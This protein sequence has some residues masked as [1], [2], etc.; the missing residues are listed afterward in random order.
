MGTAVRDGSRSGP[1]EAWGSEAGSRSSR[2]S[3]RIAQEPGATVGIEVEGDGA[4]GVPEQNAPEHGGG[5][6]EGRA[7]IAGCPIASAIDSPL[8]NASIIEGGKPFGVAT[9][10]RQ[11]AMAT[12]GA[13]APRTAMARIA[14]VQG[15][16]DRFCV[17][18]GFIE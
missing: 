14:A 3:S 1:H 11:P 8:T 13:R 5:A 4:A 17:A 7:G 10:P 18:S 15:H 12:F 2:R 6:S 16:A 9:W